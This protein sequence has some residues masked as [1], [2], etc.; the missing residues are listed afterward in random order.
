MGVPLAGMNPASAADRGGP[1]RWVGFDRRRSRTV[2]PDVGVDP[3]SRRAR[4]GRGAA[5]PRRLPPRHAAPLRPCGP[6]CAFAARDARS[7]DGVRRRRRRAA[8]RRLDVRDRG[9]AVDGWTR[10]TA[11]TVDVAAERCAAAGVGR[12]LCTA[13]ARDGTLTGPDL[14]LLARVC[15]ESGLPV[16]T[17]GGIR[18]S[19]DL[20]RGRRRRQRARDRGS[21]ASGRARCRCPSSRPGRRPIRARPSLAGRAGGRTSRAERRGTHGCRRP[22]SR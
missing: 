14:D 11:I 7:A 21:R 18:S 3:R 16:T 17:A 6:R 19:A 15:A 8:G 9:L 10:T 5:R 12:L 4:V 20:R 2:S 13:I 1:G 22:R